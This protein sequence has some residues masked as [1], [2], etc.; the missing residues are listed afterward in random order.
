MSETEFGPLTK[1]QKREA[2][3][4]VECL[5]YLEDVSKQA[6]FVL[7]T[8]IINLAK[9]ATKELLD[10]PQPDGTN[11]QRITVADIDFGVH[12]QKAPGRP[13]Q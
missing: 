5:A 11:G 4:L 1:A 2:V 10:R 12:S 13:L 3:A 7:V 6:G 8:H 9:G